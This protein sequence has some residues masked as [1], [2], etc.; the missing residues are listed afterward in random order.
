[1]CSSDLNPHMRGGAISTR[2]AF[3]LGSVGAVIASSAP[4]SFGQLSPGRQLGPTVEP[5][6]GKTVKVD[7]I[8]AERPCALPCFGG[9]ALPLWTFSEKDWLPVI[10]LDLGDRLEAT[11]RN[12]LGRKDESTSIHWHGIRLPNDQDGVPFLVQP[13]V[14]PG[15]SF[16]YAFEPPDTGTYFFHTHCNTAE[17][18]G[19]GLEGLLIVDG[20]VTEPY[21]ADVVLLMRDWHVDLSSGQFN[22][23][24][25]LRG[26]GRAGSYGAVRSVNGATNPQIALPSG[27]DCRVRLI[28]SD[29][30]RIMRVRIDGAEAAV[31][32]IDGAAI[33]P[34]Q[35][36]AIVMGPAMRADLV[37]R[38]PEA[39]KIARLVDDSGGSDVQLAS[40]AGK[41]PLVR[42]TAFD[43]APLRAPR[44]PQPDLG[45]ARRFRLSLD[46]SEAGGLFA[47]PLDGKIG[48]AHV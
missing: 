18:L 8:A 10:R 9:A 35:P 31:V 11:L 26:A 47:E 1:M 7:L 3:A 48:R 38:A 5:A 15:E 22:P 32:A 42:R 29:P 45:R 36:K 21:D 13:L 30:T 14:H 2:R 17:Q 33:P 43:P 46:R 23:F 16:R 20:D 27:G 44:I 39:G 19:R 37:L 25:S 28:N 12:R 24:F 4:R 40:F 6:A 34:F 41:G